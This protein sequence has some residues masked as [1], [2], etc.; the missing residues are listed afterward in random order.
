M[1]EAADFISDSDFGR[2]EFMRD[3]P[4]PPPPTIADD[5]QVRLFTADFPVI[6]PDYWNIANVQDSF[7]RLYF[8][9]REG[10]ALE[11]GD[12]T[13]PLQPNQIYLIPAGMR[14]NCRCRQPV[15][16]F[17][18]HFD[19]CGMALL[20][21]QPL[22]TGP[23]QLSPST[24]MRQTLKQLSSLVTGK[25]S[26]ATQCRLKSFVYRV[27]A[28]Y[29]ESLPPDTVEGL[30]DRV[31]KFQPIL[32]ALNYIEENLSKPLPNTLLGK[33]CHLQED[34]FSRRFREFTGVSPQQYIVGRRVTT[35]A[36]MLLFTN[37]SIEKIAA[38]TGFVNRNYFT[39]IFTRH[40]GS[41]PAAYRKEARR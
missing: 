10:A 35:A 13:Y 21:L 37:D 26:L 38:S 9:A 40:T 3:Y 6:T 1:P 24:A 29:L 12:V 17:Y 2:A 28:A 32:P 27:L 33:L 23:L 11:S 15:R 25:I 39:R 22:F 41:S 14:F 20:T 19:V 16:H 34:Y 7:W 5:L 4:S 30:W 18:I 8:N 36:Q 31:F